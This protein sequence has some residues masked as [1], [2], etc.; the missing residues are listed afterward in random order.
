MTL[1]DTLAGSV[2][3]P[4]AQR[5]L[6]F[7]DLVDLGIDYCRPHLW[8]LYKTRRFPQPVKLS[9]SRNAWIEAEVLAWIAARI[10]ERDGQ[11]AA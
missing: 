4:P 7:D 1:R 6:S 8:R 11:S 10:A 2:S 9:A 5:L 3:L